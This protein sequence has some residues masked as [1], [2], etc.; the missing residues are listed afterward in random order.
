MT[1]DRQ[2]IFIHI[3]RGKTGTTALQQ[4]LADHS[5]AL[6]AHG[7]L[8]PAAAGGAQRIGHDTFGKAFIDQIPCYMKPPKNAAAALEAMRTEIATSRAPYI[9]ISTEQLELANPARVREFFDDIA[10][11]FDL[12]VLFF[13]RSQ[14]ELVE[15]EYNQL[16]KMRRLTLSLAEYTDQMFNG[17]FLKTALDWEAA[18]GPG[19]VLGTVYDARSPR[20][21]KQI[22]E[23]MG[24]ADAGA[25]LPCPA[26]A[27]T[28]LRFRAL[29]TARLLNSV[30]LENRAA[31][32]A[33]IQ[34]DTTSDDPPALF[35]DAV[36][37]AK[38]RARFATSTR[39]FSKRFLGV[40]ADDLGGRRY[41]DAERNTIRRR[42]EAL[43]L[44]RF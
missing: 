1:S 43:R 38:F 30:E 26:S 24:L 39:A 7:V 18:F 20:V 4:V 40:E 29:A 32:Y 2:T 19:S 9:L 23:L 42:I 28:S 25:D 27:N 12:R 14:D 21:A 33:Q 36:T 11:D 37:A 10:P 44:D 5:A 34:Q 31:V 41:G 6:L 13:V 15:S 22:F 16:V 35:F 8:Y 3:G 17:D